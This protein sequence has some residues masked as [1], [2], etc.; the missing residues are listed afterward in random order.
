[1]DTLATQIAN[2]R[3]SILCLL[4]AMLCLALSGVATFAYAADTDDATDTVDAEVVPVEVL[5][6]FIQSLDSFE[7]SFEQT[8]YSANNEELGSS[9]GTIKLKRPARFVWSY[10]EPEPQLIVADG[11]RIWLYDSDLQQVTV[12]TIDERINGTPLQLLMRAEPLS[13]GFDVQALGPAEGIDWFS[14]IPLTQDS[15]FEEVYIGLQNDTLAAM[16]LRDSFEQATQ[17]LLSDFRKNVELDDATFIF[18]VP[19]GV[20]VIGLDE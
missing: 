20:D 12:N 14:L 10:D 15:D 6:Q 18:D 17:I 2:A 8:L 7:A 16:E 3:L 5:E 13:E 9:S 1:M 19:E 4:C 11:Q